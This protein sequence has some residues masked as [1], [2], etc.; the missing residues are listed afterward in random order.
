MHKSY[1]IVRH[2][3]ALSTF[4]VFLKSSERERASNPSQKQLRK[5]RGQLRVARVFVCFRSGDKGTLARCARANI[6]KAADA[7][8]S[9]Y[10][11]NYCGVN[12]DGLIKLPF[13]SAI[14]L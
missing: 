6:K 3:V 2:F 10:E 9:A 11:G 13:T 5:A 4:F 7:A 12:P 8:Y 1:L 14:C